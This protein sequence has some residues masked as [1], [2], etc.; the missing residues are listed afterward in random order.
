MELRPLRLAK[1]RFTGLRLRVE[2]RLVAAGFAKF[3]GKM[4][5]AFNFL[6]VRALCSEATARDGF[7]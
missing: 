5:P 3:F 6:A 4:E 1:R 2:C 7:L